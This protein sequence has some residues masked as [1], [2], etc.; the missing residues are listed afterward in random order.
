MPKMKIKKGDR[1]VVI[2]GRDK[3]KS[4]EVV[5]VLPSENRVVVSGINV[6]KLFTE[7]RPV[8]LAGWIQGWAAMPYMRRARW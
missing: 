8:D 4:G 1:V 7:P 5:R 3:G 6:M 2:T